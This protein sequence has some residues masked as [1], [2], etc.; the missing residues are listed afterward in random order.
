MTALAA[1]KGRPLQPLISLGLLYA[2]RVS[3]IVVALFFMP[4]YS[5]LLGPG[6][7]GVV[8]VIL[9]LQAMLLMMDL[10][11][12][13]LVSRDLSLTAHSGAALRALLY[14]A[15]MT[16]LLL[17]ALFFTGTAAYGMVFGWELISPGTALAGVLLFFLLV[18]QN[19]YYAAMLARR[20]IRT[21]SIIMAGGVALRAVV[22]LVVL[23]Y[24]SPTIIGFVL[25]QGASALVHM[26]VTRA[27]LLLG[28]AGVRYGASWASARDEVTRF[29]K[30]GAPV[31]LF[32][33]A[34]AAVMQL[35]K[36]I[37]AA[38][39]SAEAVAPYFLAITLCM[40]PMS[41]LAGPVS[42]YFQP[43]LLR[44]IGECDDA[45]SRRLIIR[46]VIVILAVTAIPSLVFWIERG[47]FIDLWMG[48]QVGNAA[49][50]Q[51]V[52]VLLP[53]FVIGSLGY[54]PYGLLLA[55]EDFRFQ[56]LMS[57]G[58]TGITLAATLLLA[59]QGDILGICLVYSTY[60][61]ASTLFSWLR[62][63]GLHTTRSLAAVSLSIACISIMVAL[64]GL[65]LLQYALN[66]F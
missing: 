9:S 33:L 13:V 54:V 19:V 48:K 2:G 37:I 58:L 3:G 7:F 32:S 22:T 66:N 5:R 46:F 8:A 25:A 31:A 20:E 45:R 28:A 52:S 17:Y 63:L 50:A 11:V 14:S 51:Y 61:S 47:M 1:Q 6:Q 49:I 21:A 15:E 53:G 23:M 39:M 60:H 43:M 44:A 62:A 40:L 10:G 34:G 4:A 29:I 35:D 55:A 42:Q 56:A 38:S 26:L 65:G 64:L 24:W 18:L 57:M 41:I 27:A 30:R 12:S 59:G 16:L 36:P